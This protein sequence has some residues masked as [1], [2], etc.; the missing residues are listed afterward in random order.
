MS[1]L[2]LAGAENGTLARVLISEG[3]T[4]LL[5]S[6]FWLSNMHR[7]GWI[8]RLKEQHPELTLYLDSGAY[9]YSQK[10]ADDDKGKLP[11][12][13]IFFRQYKNYLEEFGH[14]WDRVMEFDVDS[15]NN[16]IGVSVDQAEVW[17]NELLDQFPELN[18]T[19]VYHSWRGAEVWQ[20][21]VD[22]PRVRCLAIGRDPPA[23]GLMRAYVD[24]AH[25][26]G[27]PVHGLAYTKYNTGLK[28]IPFDT[29]DSSSWISGQRYGNFYV[30]K[31]G[32]I[33][34]M[35]KANRLDSRIRSYRNYIAARG[36]DPDKVI[37]GDQRETLL[38]NIRTWKLVSKRLELLRKQQGDTIL[39]LPGDRPGE[40][41]KPVR[42]SPTERLSKSSSHDLRRLLLKQTL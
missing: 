15:R 28:Y 11:P 25:Q 14:L 30:Y 37:R 34:T 16:E 18:I 29:V 5:F 8:V 24:K 9:T 26:A 3:I 21:Y 1:T 23:D 19:P 31:N 42:P 39:E 40:T 4:H 10:I 27:K 32:Q 12:P 20:E 7:E 41:P 35:T 22:D 33:L 6:Y 17:L 38:C 13:K 36:C 2:V